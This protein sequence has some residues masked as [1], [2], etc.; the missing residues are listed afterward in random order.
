MRI[1]FGW[2]STSEVPARYVHL[3]RRDVN[4]A[5]ARFYGWGAAGAGGSLA[6]ASGT[7]R[8]GSTA[9]VLGVLSETEAFRVEEAWMRKEEIVERVELIK[10]APDLLE[11]A[12][13]SR[14]PWRR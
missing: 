14:G 4:D 1:Y 5:L 13:S 11:G 10:L 9:L 7:P 8:E 6:A 12:L 2:T 3:S